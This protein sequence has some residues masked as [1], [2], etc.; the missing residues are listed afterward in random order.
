MSEMI[1]R[2]LEGYRIE[3]EL[4]RGGQAVVYRAT[5]LSLQRT[6]ALKVVSQQLSSDDH[7][8][9]RFTREGIAAASLDHAHVIPVFEAGEAD[10]LAFLAMKFVDG[11]S[12]DAVLHS[13]GGIEPRRT[14]AILRQVAEALDYMADRGMVHR[15]VKPANIL[16]GPGDHAYL[17]DF[18]LIKAMS[19]AKLTSS[20]VWMGTLEYVAPEQIRGGEITPA[21]DRYA[22]AALAFEALTGRVLFPRE[23]R[24]ATLFAHVN[25]PPPAASS[26]NPALG[27]PVDAVLARGLAK[28]PEAR[29]PTA[30]ALVDELTQAVR[31]TPGAADARPGGSAPA[32]VPPPPPVPAGATITGESRTGEADGSQAVPE[33][34]GARADGAPGPGR[35]RM[36]AVVGGGAVVIIAIVVGILFATG[37][38]GGGDRTITTAVADTTGVGTG[39]TT[40]VTPVGEYSIGAVLPSTVPGWTVTPTDPSLPN[41]EVPDSATVEA[42]QII[43]GSQVALVGGLGVPDGATDA[44]LTQLAGDLGGPEAG[45]PGLGP[46]AT[47]G[48]VRTVTDGTAVGFSTQGTVVLVLSADRLTAVQL[49]QAMTA[50]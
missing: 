11:P 4:G 28:E 49:A 41:I 33:V 1:G 5:Q 42:A 30:V 46:A 25:D 37:A 9:E 15:D 10:G 32:A 7:F 43:R 23:D 40:A 24:T 26:F 14:L 36:L 50:G 13:P 45:D 19:A 21:A 29:H 6:V 34:T 2:V 16:L 18:G 31:A 48:W 39:A 47:G 12:F 17:S 20:G 22:L 27:V 35:G 3:A 8:K 44:A 38:I